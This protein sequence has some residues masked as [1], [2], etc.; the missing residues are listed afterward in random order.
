MGIRSEIK[1]VIAERAG[2]FTGA[3]EAINL[4]ANIVNRPKIKKSLPSRA[5][6]AEE[7]LDALLKN[8]SKLP[9]QDPDTGLLGRS[10]PVL[11]LTLT[12]FCDE[13]VIKAKVDHGEVPSQELVALAIATLQQ[14]S[15]AKFGREI[16]VEDLTEAAEILKKF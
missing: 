16:K 11:V 15:K 8:P 12:H 9:D 4:I 2:N 1:A 3:S 5:A 13:E 6:Q 14:F 10:H 7:V